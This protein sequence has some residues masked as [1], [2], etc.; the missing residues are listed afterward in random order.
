MKYFIAYLER[1]ETVGS[2]GAWHPKNA[3]LDEHPLT[4]IRRPGPA[5][6]ITWWTSVYGTAADHPAGPDPAMSYRASPVDKG[7]VFQAVKKWAAARAACARSKNT[8]HVR[9]SDAA[10]RELMAVADS[11]VDESDA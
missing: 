4:W 6:S 1:E 2:S 3:M 7:L 8:K 11:L 5:R 10:F 9:D